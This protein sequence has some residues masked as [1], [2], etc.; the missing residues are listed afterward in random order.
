MRREFGK[1]KRFRAGEFANQSYEL[2][3]DTTNG[4]VVNG[5]A[6]LRRRAARRTQQR[7]GQRGDWNVI[8]NAGTLGVATI[9]RMGRLTAASMGLRRR[10]A[11]TLCLPARRTAVF[12]LYATMRERRSRLGRK[13]WDE[14]CRR[15][16]AVPRCR[17][18]SICRDRV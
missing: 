13:C 11:I 10:W 17:C 7:A 6:C 3:N 5:L 2:C 18:F 12:I 4:T 14:C 16:Q 8:A 9:A 15:V 1:W